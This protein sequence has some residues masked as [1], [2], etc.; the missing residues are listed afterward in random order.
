M[1]RST[2]RRVVTDE[3]IVLGANLDRYAV[4]TGNGD[5]NGNGDEERR[6]RNAQDHVMSFMEFGETGGRSD[7]LFRN[8]GIGHCAGDVGH[9]R[10]MP[11]AYAEAVEAERAARQATILEE[12]DS[13]VPPAYEAGGLSPRDRKSPSAT[14]GLGLRGVERDRD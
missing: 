14:M 7:Q 3:G 5:E 4:P 8:Y 10:T 1:T 13:D 2:A 12:E 9:R 6:E 11:E